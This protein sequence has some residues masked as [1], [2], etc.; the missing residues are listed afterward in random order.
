MAVVLC[1][2]A[3]FTAFAAAIVYT[4]G[5]LTAQANGRL[6][7]ERCYQLAK[8]YA[9]VLDQELTRYQTIEEAGDNT[10]YGFANKFLDGSY[11]N[12][13]PGNPQTI[14]YYQPVATSQP[15]KTYGDVTVA[16]YKETDDN[17]SDDVMSG[18]L[19]ASEGNYTQQIEK[20]KENSIIQYII[21]V[22]VIAKYNDSSYTYSTEYYR[23]EN[24]QATFSHNGTALVWG[25]DNNW[26]VGS[27]AGEVY[28][29]EITT[30][31]PVSYTL[32][33][34]QVLKYV[35]EPVHKE[36]GSNEKD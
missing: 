10:F 9:K 19:Q 13:D 31:N 8:S 32:D 4:A 30:D 14:F 26:H 25:S 5:L 34:K 33:K 11:E 21:T 7:Q 27:D 1:A 15:D 18:T 16:M 23:K 22:E 12:Y 36:A 3:F 6:E 29:G 24:Y 35:Y 20:L 28:Q 17:G 2:A